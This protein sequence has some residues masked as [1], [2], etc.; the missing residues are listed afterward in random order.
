MDANGPQRVLI[1]R[2]VTVVALGKFDVAEAVATMLARSICRPG[3]T[4]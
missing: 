4:R 2:A 1:Q 3:T